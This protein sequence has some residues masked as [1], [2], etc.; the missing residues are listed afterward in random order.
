MPRDARTLRIRLHADSTRPLTYRVN[1]RRRRHICCSTP[2]YA[3][4][5]SQRARPPQ[6]QAFVE[7][8]RATMSNER[9][10]KPNRYARFH[11][12]APQP[13]ERRGTIADHDAMPAWQRFHPRLP[14]VPFVLTA[15]GPDALVPMC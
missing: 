5:R 12:Y 3:R 13:P 11:E 10:R 9:A 1:A 8:D 2:L 15:A 4:V 7:A 14:R 6:Y